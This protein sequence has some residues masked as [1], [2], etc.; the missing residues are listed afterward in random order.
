MLRYFNKLAVMAA[1][2]AVLFLIPGSLAAQG[3]SKH[4]AVPS[5]RALTVT[6]EVLGKQGFE[7]VR[8]ARDGDVQVVYYRRGNNGKGKGRGKL[9]KMIIRREANRV[10]F[11][12]TP[13][14]ILVDIDIRLHL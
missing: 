8:V 12:D 4:Y 2:V 6:R 1:A 14:A 11:V 13:P 3:K 7:V 10:V 5:D 9:E